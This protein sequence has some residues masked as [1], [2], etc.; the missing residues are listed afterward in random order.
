MIREGLGLQ[1]IRGQPCALLMISL[2]FI[3]LVAGIAQFLFS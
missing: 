3:E 2:F 1:G